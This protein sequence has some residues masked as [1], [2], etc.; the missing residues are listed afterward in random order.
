VLQ[1]THICVPPSA[2]G[3][4]L[5]LLTHHFQHDPISKNIENLNQVIVRDMVLI[6]LDFNYVQ[7]I[8]LAK[9]F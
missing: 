4:E 1:I 9:I 6:R 5:P 3:Q 7:N 8:F 2:A